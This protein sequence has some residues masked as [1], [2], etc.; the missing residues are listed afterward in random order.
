MEDNVME[1]VKE[2][3][4]TAPAEA[5][6][7]TPPGLRQ[8]MQD[9]YMVP[10]WESPTAHKLDVAREQAHLWP[11]H[12][13]R[14]IMM[15]TAE[16]RSP[17]VVE[18][19][20][21]SLVNPKS[22]SAEDEATAGVLN[23]TLQML[24]PGERARPHRHSMNALRFVLEGN[25]GETIVDGK[26]CAMTP[27]DLIITPAWCWH[28]HVSSGTAP[29]I[30][31]DV[32]DVALHLS[33]GTD[34]FQPGPV[35]DLRPQCDDAAFA[36]VGVMPCIDADERSYSP[37]FRYPWTD[38][39]TALEAAPQ[40]AD[41]SRRA[42]YVNPLSGGPVMSL[43]DCT[44]VELEAAKPTR[45]FRSSASTVCCVVEGGGASEIGG[46]TIN[47]EPKDVFTVPQGAWVSHRASADN[48]RIFMVSNREVYRRLGLLTEAWRD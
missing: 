24:L 41:G 12:E 31:L 48:A 28:E 37:Y 1:A 9:A 4:G 10:L 7:P 6:N 18:R 22:K 40:D 47:W 19:R 34:D 15:A 16:V 20:V 42:R 13:T 36:A 43:I 11:W 17:K 44:L 21:I 38:A 45:A 3:A 25:G 32:L 26:H 2:R 8:A 23:A 33:L 27:G 5:A 29:T 30:W 46:K 39:V 14:P 35:R